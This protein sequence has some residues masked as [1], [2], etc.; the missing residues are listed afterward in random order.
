MLNSMGSSNLNDDKVYSD[1]YLDL[2][3]YLYLSLYLDLYFTMDSYFKRPCISNATGSSNL[4]DKMYLDLDHISLKT[5]VS[6]G[7]CNQTEN[8]FWTYPV[9]IHQSPT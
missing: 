2:D 1:M 4:N 8:L 9:C 6:P 3:L 7:F 5:T